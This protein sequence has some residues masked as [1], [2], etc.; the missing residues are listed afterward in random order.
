M[1]RIEDLNAGLV[2]VKRRDV[3]RRAAMVVDY[4]GVEF[5]LRRYLFVCRR[6]EAVVK[7]VSAIGS[8]VCVQWWVRIE[9]RA[10]MN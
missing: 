7:Q 9:E 4:G 1:Q 6:D 5:E 2:A 3:L 8:I 10:S